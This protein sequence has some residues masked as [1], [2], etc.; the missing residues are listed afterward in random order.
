MKGHISLTT[1]LTIIADIIVAHYERNG[2]ETPPGPYQLTTTDKE[3]AVAL[4]ETGGGALQLGG[5]Y[6]CREQVLRRLSSEQTARYEQILARKPGHTVRLVL[7]RVRKFSTSSG[8]CAAS[9][10]HG[11]CHH[12]PSA[13]IESGNSFE[14]ANESETLERSLFVL[15]AV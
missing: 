10:Q 11:I 1:A 8:T 9:L 7:P 13:T 3:V 2:K 5:H 12:R 15:F 14:R 4:S 6:F